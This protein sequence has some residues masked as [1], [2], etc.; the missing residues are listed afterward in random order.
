MM[1]VQHPFRR[2]QPLACLP[3]VLVALVE[4]TVV[5]AWIQA[6]GRVCGPGLEKQLPIS[7]STGIVS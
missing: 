6:W 2:P 5:E 7:R 1:F 4:L 3:V